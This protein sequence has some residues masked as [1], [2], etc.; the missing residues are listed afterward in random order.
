MTLQGC[1]LSLKEIGDL[2]PCNAFLYRGLLQAS[3]PEEGFPGRK[4]SISVFGSPVIYSL[5]YV[6]GQRQ[7]GIRVLAEPDADTVPQ[8]IN[9]SLQFVS[10][11]SRVLEWDISE[12]VNKLTSCIYPKAWT[13]TLDWLGG[14]W[15]GLDTAE[16]Q[17]M[18]KLYMN[19]R[20][21]P[22]AVRWQKIAD[23]IVR[24]SRPEMEP[25]IRF[26]MDS[27][28]ESGSP[29]GIGAGL[30]REGLLGLRIYV[31]F[32]QPA[33]SS[34]DGIW[35]RFAPA[36]LGH[37]HGM[38]E[39]YS[40]MFPFLPQTVLTVDFAAGPGRLLKPDPV[41]LKTELS[42]CMLKGKGQEGF[43]I[44]LK[45]VSDMLWGTYD[46]LE[47]DIHK[48]RAIFP[49]L[50]FQYASY[51]SSVGAVENKRKEHFTVYIE[52]LERYE[53]EGR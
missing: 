45:K 39:L 34:F 43:E 50:F 22:L 24:Y 29:I 16:K 44:Y 20:H 1:C 52:P 3:F 18:L 31:S 23:V 37:V 12:D 48:M 38:L 2:D 6:E 26:I 53:R 41:R 5:K 47:Q 10:E 33:A 42:G 19:L 25:V 32:G 51:G 35:E 9:R 46:G 40:D 4:N 14:M 30:G 15:I 21:Q 28:K 8:Q 49:S 36:G 17:P 11:A 27:T 7:S 13:E